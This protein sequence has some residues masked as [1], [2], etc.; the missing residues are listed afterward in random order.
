MNVAEFLLAGKTD[1]ARP[2]LHLL[3]GSRTYEEL[4]SAS[5]SVATF[6][7]AR[8]LR[9][10]DRV[11]LVAENSFFWV[12][13]YLGILLAGLVCV[14]LAPTVTNAELLF[15]CESTEPVAAFLTRAFHKKNSAVLGDALVVTNDESPD[16]SLGSV[17]FGAL[18]SAHGGIATSFPKTSPDDLAALMYTSGSTAQPRG[19]MITHR[20]ICANTESIVQYLRLTERDRA[21]SVLPFHYCFGTSVLHSH[22]RAGGS[23]VIDHR[24]MYPEAVLRRMQETE[25]TG[26]AGVPSHYQV[27]L[28]RSNLKNM[29]FP[30]LR[31]V[32]QAG[33]HLSPA[34]VR[35]LQTA[36]PNAQVFVMYG[37]TEATARLAYLPPERLMEKLGSIGVAIPGVRL[38]VLD[39]SA[40]DVLPG[41]QGE[42]VAEGENVAAGYWRDP[43]ESA[44]SFRNGLLYTGDLATVDS[45]G[46]IYI[47]DRAKDFVKVGGKRI[48]CRQV[49][50]KLTEFDELL[51]VAVI[52]VPDPV[53]GEA[54]KAFVVPKARPQKGFEESVRKFCKECLPPS[55]LP[56]EIVTLDSLPKN[57]G[58]KVMKQ[59]LKNLQERER[60]VGTNVSCGT[61]EG[62]AGMVSR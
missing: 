3:E 34:F 32:Q 22:L 36:L 2:A 13:S 25:C 41:Q 47:V 20:N 53:L 45:D 17:G 44:V 30:V 46:F 5:F 15:I 54:L 33:G 4:D 38:R 24:F 40:R 58:G 51:E 61:S 56:R 48:S 43:V 19:V 55:L 16:G 18:L 9:K 29:E 59:A 21:M 39:A 28:R 31:Y 27:L 60:T 52:G 50:E 12:A 8:D 1:A 11:L 35:E 57:S 26:F 10:G 42:V 49:E 62:V 37:Q 14:P 6:L 23:L 7:L